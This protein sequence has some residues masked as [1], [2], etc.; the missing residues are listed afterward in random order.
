MFTFILEIYRVSFYSWIIQGSLHSFK[1]YRVFFYSFRNI[2]GSLLFLKYT[3]F[4]FILLEI[5]RVPFYSF[6]NVQ[7]SL[8][9][10]K[11]TGFP[12]IYYYLLDRDIRQN[13]YWSRSTP[14]ISRLYPTP[15]FN[16]VKYTI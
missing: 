13:Y 1:I 8:L 12:F 3:G 14:E 9:F 2:Q 4:P 6:R 16:E 10:L 7:G 15:L 5:Y 11:S